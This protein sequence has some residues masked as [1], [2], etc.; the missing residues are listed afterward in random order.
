[1]SPETFG[2]PHQDLVLRLALGEGALFVLELVWL[3][4]HVTRGRLA[5]RQAARFAR[6]HGDQLLE[7]LRDPAARAG[8]VQAARAYPRLLVRNF[9]EPLLPMTEGEAREALGQ[10]W[11]DLGFLAQDL[12]MSRSRLWSRRM[13]AM[14]R[15]SLVAGPGEAQALLDRSGDRHL[16]RIMAAQTLVRVGSPAELRECLRRLTLPSRLLE[17]PVVE[18]LSS[19]SPEQVAAMLEL[20]SSD[21]DPCV[22]RIVLLTAAR[23]DPGRCLESIP[24]AATSSEKEVRIGACLAAGT[25]GSHDLLPLMLRALA[26]DPAFEVRAQAAKALGRLRSP[27]GIAGLARALEDRAFWVRQNAAAAL[28]EHGDSGR[29]QL[30]EIAARGQDRFAVDTARQELR[31]LVAPTPSPLLSQAHV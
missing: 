11:R 6:R 16:I 7:V 22:R 20:L 1:M 27:E 26:E 14:R 18:A 12:A 13:R 3:V 24:A 17:Q 15:L 30:E 31:R 8:W 21:A 5:S 28:R 10:V 29:L 19:A 25:L 23:V 9:L 4:L 2:G